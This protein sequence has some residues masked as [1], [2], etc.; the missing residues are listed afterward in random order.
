MDSLSQLKGKI[1]E[2]RRFPPSFPLSQEEANLQ[3][4][5]VYLLRS[6]WAS[7]PNDRLKEEKKAQFIERVMGSPP[8]EEHIALASPSQR[9]VRLSIDARIILER[10]QNYRCALCGRFLDREAEPHVDH[11]IP[12]A[13]GG[14][15]DASNFQLLCSK[16][17]LGKSSSL[18]WLT[19][20][21]FFEEPHGNEPSNR[22]RYCALQR[23]A[24]KCSALGCGGSSLTDELR[25]MQHIPIS[26]GGRNILDNLTV[27][28]Q[29][30]SESHVSDLQMQARSNMGGSRGFRFF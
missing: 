4:L 20:A 29:H 28:C 5:T 10:Q 14:K 16:C 15:E 12:V 1:A 22:M 21:P 2:L 19:I 30:H 11:I 13:F 18:H 26:A 7:L 27:L 6:I 25:V 17:N 23:H 3:G 9:R 24:G 8:S